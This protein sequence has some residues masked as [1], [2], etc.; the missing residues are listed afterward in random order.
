MPQQVFFFEV[1]ICR[2]FHIVIAKILFFVVNAATTIKGRQLFKGGNYFLKYGMKNSKQIEHFHNFELCH[3]FAG[4]TKS[5][6]TFENTNENKK[7]P[8]KFC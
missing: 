1:E 2:K 8:A 7:S 4:L 3:T 5:T 6:D